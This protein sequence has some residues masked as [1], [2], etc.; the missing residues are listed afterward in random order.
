VQGFRPA[1]LDDL[2]GQGVWLWQSLGLARDLPR[3]AFF[4]RDFEGRPA[5]AAIHGAGPDDIVPVDEPSSE[6]ERSS[7]SSEAALATGGGRGLHSA[8]AKPLEPSPDLER[9]M[10]ILGQH[11]ASFAT[12]LARLGAIEPSRVRRG[13]NELMTLGLV[14]NDRFDP[15]RLGAQ[16]ALV[17]LT[18]ASSSRRAG[19]AMRGG[20]RR[21]RPSRPEGRWSRLE[22]PTGDPEARLLSWAAVLIERYGVLTREVVALEPFAPAWAEIAPL[23]SRSEL[24]G[25]LRRGYFVEGLSGVQYASQEAADD[26]ARLGAAPQENAPLVVVCATDPANLYGA[27]APLD[28]ELLEGG[29]ARLPRLPGHFLVLRAGRPVLIIESYGKR[30]TGLASARQADI[31]SALNF[32]TG[33]TGQHR[34]ILKVESYN[35]APAAESPIAATLTTLGFVRDYPGMAYYAGWGADSTG[36]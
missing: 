24:R 33:F 22:T 12:D 20:P 3:V 16:E 19:L 34:R 35:G 1:W 14:T 26:L 8:S 17:A 18:S 4:L 9:L 13:L 28:V 25:E 7:A 21:S 10:E 31:D 15:L 2:L 27:G 32:L 23:L 5:G 6:Q 30:L 11:G 36:S 29:V